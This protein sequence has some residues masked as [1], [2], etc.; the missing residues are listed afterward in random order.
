MQYRLSLRPARSVALTEERGE[1]TGSRPF[2]QTD[3]TSETTARA[4]GASIGASWAVTGPPQSACMIVRPPGTG[5]YGTTMP[6]TRI[7][8][9]SQQEYMRYVAGSIANA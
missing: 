4:T 9:P 6:L 1:I 8:E 7:P 3:E 2:L 5:E